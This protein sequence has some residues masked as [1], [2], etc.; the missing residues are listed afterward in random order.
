MIHLVLNALLTLLTAG[1]LLLAGYLVGLTVAA[2]FGRRKSPPA[3]TATR[4]F[5]ILVPAHN[6]EVLIRRLLENLQQ[7]D[8][9]KSRFDVHLVADNCNDHTAPLARSLGAQV[10]ERFDTALEGKG[11]ALR[12][13]LEQIQQDGRRYDAFV[14]LDADSV[15]AANFLQSMDARLAAGSQVI[16]AYYSVLNAGDSP[17]AALRYAALAAVHYLRPLGRSALGL[18]CGLKGNGMCFAAPVLAQFA[19]RWFTLAEDV[20]FHLALAQAGVRVDFA[21]ETSVLADMPISY[22]Q[23]ASQN[24]RWERG[25]LQLLR[26]HVPTLLMEGMRRRS[27]LRI[28]A[29]AE[30]L[31][32]PLSV[33]FALGGLGLVAGLVFGAVVPTTLAALSLGGQIVYLLVALILVRAPLSTY[34]ALRHAP[35]YVA[36]KVGVYGQGLL[37][38]RSMRWIRTARAVATRDAGPS[39][40]LPVGRVMDAHV[41]E[42]K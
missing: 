41:G 27:P 33:P 24:A 3:S 26:H 11:F 32:P 29:A 8:Y 16:Q 6:E 35:V 31:I 2:L 14:V 12:W 28:D 38:T 7:L 5:A 1:L 20:E 36:W 9:P 37:R 30:Q 13:L 39:V 15:V 10:Y 22:A 25:R 18:S 34:L 17:V 23:A 40:A 21:P 19:W 4:R 42:R